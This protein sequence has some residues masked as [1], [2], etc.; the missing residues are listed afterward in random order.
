MG[1]QALQWSR[2]RFVNGDGYTSTGQGFTGSHMYV[3]CG[4]DPVNRCDP[5]GTAW[6]YNG[7]TYNYDGSMADFRRAE[8]GLSPLAYERATTP[9]PNS[10]GGTY[11]TKSQANTQVGT[12]TAKK[13][14][15]YVPGNKINDLKAGKYDKGVAGLGPAFG[16]AAAGAVLAAIP[17]KGP[18]AFLGPTGVAISCLEAWSA[19]YDWATSTQELNT[20]NRAINNNT[21][22]VYITITVDTGRGVQSSTI[23]QEWDNYPYVIGE[24]VQ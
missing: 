20:L 18:T 11:V 5:S 12:V 17:A 21:G 14:S 24:K 19:F 7:V 9:T 10:G 8:Q 1:C 15:T 13:T 3:Y 16:G 2:G 4:N 23:V 6:V 22:V